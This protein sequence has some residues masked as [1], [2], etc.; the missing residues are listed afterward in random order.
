MRWICHKH[1]NDVAQQAETPVKSKRFAAQQICFVAPHDFHVKL[2]DTFYCVKQVDAAMG[3]F[4][5]L[6]T[7]EV[8]RNAAQFFV[9]LS[10][11]HPFMKSH[12]LVHNRSLFSIPHFPNRE[13]SGLLNNLQKLVHA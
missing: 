5:V 6:T 2:Q 13:K 7:C 9:H 3:A 8:L 1:S 4:L 10:G 11:I 12:K